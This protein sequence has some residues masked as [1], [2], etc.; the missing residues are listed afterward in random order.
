M[1]MVS[2]KEIENYFKQVEFTDDHLQLDQCSTITNLEKFYN[3]H[4]QALKKNSGDKR[5]MPYYMR[6][7]KFYYIY[8]NSE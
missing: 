3:S 1:K 5:F 2:L 7:L 4:L 8:K 6:L